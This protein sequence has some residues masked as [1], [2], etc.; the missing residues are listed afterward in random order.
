MSQLPK[1][2][3]TPTG[4]HYF[5]VNGKR[6]YI[7]SKISKREIGYVYKLLKKSIKNKNVNTAKA[8]VNIHQEAPK[9]RRKRVP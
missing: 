2:Y 7:N 5:K 3:I 8:I 1:I 4:K 6:V 9:R